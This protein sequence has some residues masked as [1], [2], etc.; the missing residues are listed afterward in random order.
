MGP[1]TLPSHIGLFGE[2]EGGNVC[3]RFLEQH[4]EHVELHR[5][6]NYCSR[7]YTL[8]LQ[9]VRKHFQNI[10][11]LNSEVINNL[12]IVNCLLRE[13]RKW[14][15]KQNYIHLYRSEQGTM[16]PQS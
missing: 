15:S 4:R 11:G 5:S 10:E 8:N 6:A 12:I 3:I 1:L 9:S 14:G 7:V 2:G 13:S 16:Y